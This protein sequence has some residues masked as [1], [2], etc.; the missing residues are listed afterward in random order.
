MNE[1]DLDILRLGSQGYCCA[2]IIMLLALEMQGVENP[3]LI[4][5]MAG[6]CDGCGNQRATCG[7]LTGGS[8]LLAY[9]AGKGLPEQENHDALPL[10]LEELSDWFEKYVGGQY[11]G[12]T[13]AAIV[14]DGKPN[15]VVCGG[16]VAACF[17]QILRI[18][19]EHGFDPSQ[20][21]A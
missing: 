3:A 7:I 20:E 4:R 8:C 13:C 11:G 16:L 6:L 12:I 1:Y 9:Y 17:E 19:M 14:P 15:P 5:S 21:P 2:Q 10:M 18:L